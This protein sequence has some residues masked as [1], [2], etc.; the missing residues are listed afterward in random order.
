MTFISSSSSHRYL[1]DSGGL[2]FED[3]SGLSMLEVLRSS[4]RLYGSIFAVMFTVFLLGRK[5]YPKAYFVLESS[6]DEATELCKERHGTFSWMWKVFRVT[7]DELF[8]YCGMDAVCFI[9][10]LR[11]GMRVAIIAVLNGIYLFPIYAT[12][13]GDFAQ[14]EAVTLGNVP[15][16]S[17][18]LLSAT[19][20]CY[21]VYTSALY[22]LFKE[23]DWYTKFRHKF[24]AQERVNNYSIYVKFI[25]PHL[26][27]NEA[28]LGYFRQVFSREAVVDAQITLQIPTLEKAAF[29]RDVICG[30]KEKIG[31]LE[32]AINILHTK[33]TRPRH[34][35]LVVTKEVRGKKC[36]RGAPAKTVDSIDEYTRQL[37]KLN[38]KISGL[39]S[40]IDVKLSSDSETTCNNDLLVRVR[41]DP[42]R[43]A[44]DEYSKEIS[45]FLNSKMNGSQTDRSDGNVDGE[46]IDDNSHQS[47]MERGAYEYEEPQCCAESK[48]P[49]WVRFESKFISGRHEPLAGPIN[50]VA[51]GT[52]GAIEGSAKRIGGSTVKAVTKT[53]KYVG[54]TA[55]LAAA[56]AMT[57]PGASN[58]IG[59]TTKVVQSVG[60]G[61]GK[62][63]GSTAKAVGDGSVIVVGSTGKLVTDT[64]K[65]VGRSAQL[66]A[67]GAFSLLFGKQDGTPLDAGFVSFSSL[68]D[69]AAALQMIHH[70]VP[71]TMY[72]EEAPL[73]EHIVWPNVGMEHKTQQIGRVIAAGLTFAL[74]CFWTVIVSF[75]VS[76]AEVDKLVKWFPKFGEWLVQAPWFLMFLN[77]LKPLLLYIIVELLPSTLKHF[78]RREGHIAETSLNTSVFFKLSIFL[79][80]QI[81]FVQMLSGTIIGQLQLMVQNPTMI[82]ELMAEAIPNQAQSFMQYCIVQTAL[83]L[84]FEMIRSTDI[85]KA[86]AR[87]VLG[88]TLT[89]AER[90]KP[91]LFFDPL[92]VPECEYFSI[93]ALLVLFFMILFTYSVM[94]PVTSVVVGISFFLFSLCYRHQLIYVY[95]KTKD[96]GGKLFSDFVGLA[97]SCILVS[98]FVMF[99]VLA[100][101]QGVLA[102]PF[103]I[104]LIVGTIMFR[105]Y[106]NQEH[107]HVTKHLPSTTAVEEDYKHEGK[108]DFDVFAKD[109]YKQ[110]ARMERFKEPENMYVLRG[111]GEPEVTSEPEFRAEEVA[112][113]EETSNGSDREGREDTGTSPWWAWSVWEADI[114]M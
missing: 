31:K 66:A 22:L 109:A 37:E 18:K 90:A 5:F 63:V 82:I 84:G 83:E 4:L 71:F 30:T 56:G 100:L 112:K 110:P 65:V 45:D 29:D 74:C 23:F 35:K 96:S 1:D 26:R 53:G 19:V 94:S 69:K 59:G 3:L 10:T 39:I 61:V 34:Q 111:D 72:V 41:R 55:Q 13:G 108:I 32:H 95:T 89:D 7:D 97:I 33:G 67:S 9:R 70:P 57:I 21:I 99:G 47:G 79:V 2:D 86:W 52:A 93:Q 101:K 62:G 77:Q 73:P 102:A 40:A 68:K 85:A 106:L 17:P 113:A 14:L 46:A 104:P 6:E 11:F 91:W 75:I 51:R 28:L 49:K 15:D 81:F 44:H 87:S 25:P 58:F 60:K 43:D 80:I 76:I 12:S 36:C 38:E 48:G 50:H 114:G 103:L 78:S 20:A 27:S 92:S 107:Y 105:M 8:E 16:G 24:L 88:P 98:E 64:G 54:D 42:E